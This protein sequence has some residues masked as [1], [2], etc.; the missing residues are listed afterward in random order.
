MNQQ[1]KAKRSFPYVTLILLV[2]LALVVLILGYTL[3]D[4]IGVIGRLDNA[5]KSN[6]IKLNENELDVYRFHVAQSQ[7]YTEFMYYQYGLMTDTYGVTSMFSNGY[8]YANYMIPNYV[9][10]GNYDATAYSYAEQYLTYCEGAMEAGLYD[11]YKDEVAEDI[12]TYIDGMKET[13]KINGVSFNKYLK[14]WIGNGVSQKDV[15][16]A[17]EYYY[18]GI[19]Y[20]EKLQEDYADAAT[21]DDIIKYRDDNKAS[22]YTTKY[23]SYKLI[24]NDWKDKFEACKTADEIKTVIVD[25]YID[26]KFSTHYETNITKKDIEDTAGMEQTKADVKTTLLALNSIG[27]AKAVFTSSDT[28]AYKKAAYAIVTA[29]NTTVSTETAKV[30]ES[31]AAWADPA[32]SSATDLQKW[33]FGTGRKAG[34]YTVLKTTSTSSSSSSSSSTTSTDTYTWYLVEETMIL[35][36]EKTKNAHYILLSDDAEGTENGMTAAQKAEAFYKA[37][38]ETKTT[39]KFA[40]LVEKYAPGYSSAL[41]EQISYESMKKSYEDLADWLYEEGRNEGDITNIPVK[42]DTKDPEKVT[43]HIIAYYVDENEET[44]KL[45]GRNSIAN[46]KVTEWFEEA[47]EKYGVTVDYEFETETENHDGHDHDDETTASTEATTQAATE[48]TT[49]AATE[50]GTTAE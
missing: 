21:E 7:L 38:S 8:D 37:L 48:A 13:A 28:D 20:A 14:S 22:F 18:I 6:N 39:E 27:D 41:V 36:T 4:S 31:S 10:S 42:G 1:A 35:D 26:Q 33:L 30:K 44:W 15:E 11:T 3:V 25:Y 19:K 2:T 46:E 16:T 12:A 45:N 47:V 17:M 34:D 43:G 29:L 24:S 23:T 49:E 5:A 32:G 50:A 9:G 40:E